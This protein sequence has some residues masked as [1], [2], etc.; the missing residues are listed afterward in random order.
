M[1]GGAWDPDPP[2]PAETD[3]AGWD[4]G[5][6]PP[7]K[8]GWGCLVATIVASAASVIALV[9]VVKIVADAFTS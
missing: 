6:R 4:T 9:L 2:A 8:A 3:D 5:A 1:T 7:R